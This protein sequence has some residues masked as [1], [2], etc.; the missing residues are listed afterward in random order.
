VLPVQTHTRSLR[1]T[2]KRL[3]REGGALRPD[4]TIRTYQTDPTHLTYPTHLT[5]STDLTYPTFVSTPPLT[6]L[7]V[8]HYI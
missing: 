2:P 6:L 8:L 4:I 1:G 3:P 5:H 7:A